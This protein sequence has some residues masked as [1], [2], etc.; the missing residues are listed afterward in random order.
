MTHP[1][2]PLI[3]QAQEA[4]LIENFLSNRHHLPLLPN[5]HEE[6]EAC[7][8]ENVKGAPE[9]LRMTNHIK[10]VPP[11]GRLGDPADWRRRIIH[12]CTD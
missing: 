5:R 10:T 6:P 12:H 3:G 4:P 9:Y 2:V 11:L 1:P 8:S 7:K